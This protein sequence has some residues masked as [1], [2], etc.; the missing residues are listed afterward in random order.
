MLLSLVV[1]CGLIFSF[2]SASSN[3]QTSNERINIST[4]LPTTSNL[5]STVTPSSKPCTLKMKDSEI[6]RI[7]ELFNNDLVH[8][9]DIS[10]SLSNV[11]H[12]KEFLSD[13]HVQLMNPIGR[14]IL[15]A[16]NLTGTIFKGVSWPLRVGI[17]DFELH[18]LQSQNACIKNRTNVTEFTLQ[19]VQNIVRNI[20]L[21]TN[22]D[23]WYSYK[24]I[25]SG[26]GRKSCCHITKL[27]M[28]ECN[29]DCSE[30]N[31]YLFR[32][33]FLWGGLF[34]IICSVFLICFGWIACDFTSR[35][36]FDVEYS[37]YYKLE[38]SRMSPSFIFFK[39]IWE[40]NGRTIACIRYYVV[41][42]GFM[43][44]FT[45]YFKTHSI[46]IALFAFCLG[47]VVARVIFHFLSGESTTPSLMEIT[48]LKNER[49]EFSL[50]GTYS[51]LVW[52][53]YDAEKLRQEL[54]ICENIGMI[55]ILTSLFNIK[56]WRKAS[57]TMKQKIATFTAKHT[58]FNSGALKFLAVCLC[59]TFIV[60]FFFI[61][62]FYLPIVPLVRSL[63]T[64]KNN[65]SLG[66]S[67]FKLKCLWRGLLDFW[68]VVPI[69]LLSFFLILMPSVTI[70]LLSGLFLNLIFF[71]P[72]LAFF[73]VLT[74]YCISYWKSMEENYLLLKQLIY[75]ACRDTKHDDN[76]FIK[77][78]LLKR[79]EKVLPVVSKK[80]Y[81]KIREKL[82]PY[83]ENLFY[84]A[85]KLLCVFA[86]SFAIFQLIIMLREFEVTGFVQVLTTA[87]LGVMPHIFNMAALKTSE[88]MKEAWKEK[89][90]LNLKYMVDELVR[91]D[92]ELVETEVVIPWREDDEHIFKEQMK[93]FQTW[94][95]EMTVDNDQVNEERVEL[96][97]TEVMIHPEDDTT[98][99][100][101]DD[102]DQVNEERV[103]PLQTEVMIHQEHNTTNEMTDDNDEVNEERVEP[104]QTEVMLHEQHDTTN[105]MTNDSDQVNEERVEPPQ[106]EVMLHEQ[107]DTTNEMTNDSD[108]VN[109][110]R[111][112]PPQTE[113]MIDR[114]HITTNEMTDDYADI[115]VRANKLLQIGRHPEDDTTNEITDAND[116]INEE[117][118]ELPQTEVMIHQEHDTT[119]EMT[120]A[121]DQINEERVEPHQTEVM[122]H[123]EHDTTNEMIDNNDQINE[124]VE[125]LE[126]EVI[127]PEEH[128]TR[129]EMPNDNHGV[130][131]RLF[132]IFRN[133][134][135]R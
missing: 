14:E 86:F 24:E 51:F 1:Y 6:S 93:L 63:R 92:S 35:S 15:F 34:L 16:L 64:F 82:L 62:V 101:T 91:D 19:T 48:Q 75:E 23:V 72:H 78:R 127:I 20:N 50:R 114:E 129:D 117:R 60:L 103:E 94:A 77:N 42:I 39:I 27:N 7:I 79:N 22:Y 49:I 21:A 61:Y 68:L 111:L 52:C 124:R 87:S 109:E 59:Y 9:V 11:S 134:R 135:K 5:S 133:R 69:V 122:I 98:N 33:S 3:N 57:E 116:Q 132:K 41:T 66:P 118:V 104:P 97:Q 65:R 95:N 18:L 4:A 45:F 89:M 130:F 12:G 96:H 71:I 73:S 113:V 90:K 56:F 25:S 76:N 26:E 102:N 17:R 40:E 121:N 10:V 70:S 74:F 88:Q 84:L 83:D 80:L 123:Q 29:D 36:D 13:F 99:E 105:E 107:H 115:F 31:S 8:V 108:Q 2:V 43:T 126:M 38:E 100:M 125:L 112:E 120:D 131:G 32:S 110:E 30:D 47:G 55:K 28:L 46:F 54:K 44:Y 53:G 106:T 128:D 58:K 85:V 37:Q 81:D 119:N 67:G